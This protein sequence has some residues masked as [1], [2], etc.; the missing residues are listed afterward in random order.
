MIRRY[1]RSEK[2][3][4]PSSGSS[5]DLTAEPWTGSAA[6][7]NGDRTLRLSPQPWEAAWTLSFCV[8]F[9]MDTTGFINLVK[10]PKRGERRAHPLRSS[11]SFVTLS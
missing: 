10:L 8:G 6:V 7:Q 5:F 1:R 4:P 3:G 9:D 2:A 11:A